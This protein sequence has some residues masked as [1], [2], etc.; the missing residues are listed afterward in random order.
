[1]RH[2]LEKAL[3]AAALIAHGMGAAAQ[4]ADGAAYPNR[5]VHVTIGLAPGGVTDAVGRMVARR[6]SAELK[7]PFIVENKPGA[8]GTIGAQ[9]VASAEP[10]GYR[11]LWA[12]SSI[13]MYPHM[14]SGLKFDPTTDL[15][16]V[17]A[18]AEGNLILL[19]R[20][21]APWKNMAEL[22]AF[23]RKNA[24]RPI[25]FANGGNGSNSH[26][27]AEVLAKA[28]NVH[29]QHIPYTTNATVITDLATGRVDL[30]FDGPGTALPQIK[31]GRVAALAVSSKDRLSSLPDVPTMQESGVK[32]YALRTWLAMFAP[33][34][35]PAAVADKLSAALKKTVAD[36][37]F[38]QELAAVLYEPF[39]LS[40]K[41]LT[42][43]VKRETQYWGAQLGDTLK[44]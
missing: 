25:M 34:G 38:Q 37:A 19:S 24:A 44:K 15:V 4:Q 21:N 5:P 29:V 42:D 41:E 22:V 35:T 1:V 36:P 28:A 20:P 33:K 40:G 30:L 10:D 6:L 2:L 3:L 23:S 16:G 39:P 31:A 18:V 9:T 12:S 8:G 17:G 26:I 43:L 7:V 14:Y 32:D 13:P 11:L 27:F